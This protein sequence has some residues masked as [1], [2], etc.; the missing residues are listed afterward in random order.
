VLKDDT[1][2]IFGNELG[3]LRYEIQEGGESANAASDQQRDDI[4]A[5]LCRVVDDMIFPSD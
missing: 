4:S 1:P 3:S 2:H 5:I